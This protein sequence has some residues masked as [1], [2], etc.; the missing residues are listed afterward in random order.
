[1]NE[2]T[3]KKKSTAILLWILCFHR[4]YFGRPFTALLQILTCGGFVFWWLLDLNSM[5]KGTMKDGKGKTIAWI[6]K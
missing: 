2:L 5:L 1:M 3:M 6:E 4:F